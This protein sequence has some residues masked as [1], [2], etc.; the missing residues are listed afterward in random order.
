MLQFALLKD[1]YH[2]D[3]PIS[4]TQV[5]MSRPVQSMYP[6]QSNQPIHLT[7][8]M[9][10]T[11][12]VQPIKTM[13]PVQPMYPPQYMQSS[14]VNLAQT[15]LDHALQNSPSSSSSV[16]P[17]PWWVVVYFALIALTAVGIRTSA[18]I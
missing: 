17:A 18:Q 11:R 7:H 2:N 13:Y 12:Y 9:N 4:T 14:W 10:S 16:L 8:P 1:V 6:T 15:P 3:D 5:P